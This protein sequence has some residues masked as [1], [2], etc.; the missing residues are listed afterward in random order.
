MSDRDVSSLCRKLGLPVEEATLDSISF[1]IFKTSQISNDIAVNAVRR[2]DD[3]F[4]LGGDYDY[5]MTGSRKHVYRDK[6]G[7][8]TFPVDLVWKL[9][10]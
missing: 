3:A 2:R 1:V 5:L 10:L 8:S 6:D 4:V 9:L 7:I